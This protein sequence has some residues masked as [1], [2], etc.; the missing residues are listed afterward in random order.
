MSKQDQIY[1]SPTKELAAQRKSLAPKTCRGIQSVQ[2]ECV[3]RRDAS[4]ED[5]TVDR[6]GC[7]ARDT[8]PVLHSGAYQHR[9]P[10]GGDGGGDHGSHLGRRRDAC[11]RRLR[12]FDL[13]AGYDLAGPERKKRAIV[14]ARASRTQGFMVV[15]ATVSSRARR[16]PLPSTWSLGTR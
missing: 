13:G 9:P 1:P 10:A 6:R 16:R 5:Q 15:R 14:N 3:C 8:M 2:S 11:R 7:G 4:R 12:T